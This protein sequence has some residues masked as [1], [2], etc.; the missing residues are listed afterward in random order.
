MDNHDEVDLETAAEPGPTLAIHTAE[1]GSASEEGP[2]LPA[3]S[4]ATQ[5]ADEARRAGTPTP[6]STGG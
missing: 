5:E 1:P 4:A 6:Q 3:S 2:R